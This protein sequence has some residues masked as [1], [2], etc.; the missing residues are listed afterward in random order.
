MDRLQ[1]TGF[2][3]AID[4]ET[5]RVDVVVSTGDVARDDM[6]IEMA[7]WQL[8]N[9]RRNPVVL[10]AHNDAALP[11]ARAVDTRIENDALVQTHEFAQHAQADTVWQLVRDGYMSATSVRWLPKAWEWRKQAGKSMETLVFT[12]SELL[13]VSWVTVP[14]DPG[15]LVI[16]SDGRPIDLAQFRPE[17]PAPASPARAVFDLSQAARAMRAATTQLKAGA[18]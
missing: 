12:A 6:I 10:F 2:A 5:R 1:L 15:A 3:R 7:G 11:I 13:E 18:K 14:A 16:R 4:A 8:D 17:P 9:Y